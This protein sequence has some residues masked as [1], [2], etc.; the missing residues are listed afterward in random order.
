MTI[1]IYEVHAFNR[2]ARHWAMGIQLAPI[3]PSL[4]PAHIAGNL[5]A[6]LA[7]LVVIILL[8]LSINYTLHWSPSTEPTTP[9]SD[10]PLLPLTPGRAYSVT[11]PTMLDGL[12]IILDRP[13]EILP[14]GSLRYQDCNVSIPLH[15]VL[16]WDR[17]WFTVLENA[18]LEL[19]RSNITIVRDPLHE[20]IL[21]CS[22]DLESFIE[23]P[24]GV[25]ILWRVVNLAGCARP[26]LAFDTSVRGGGCEIRVFAQPSPGAEARFF[27]SFVVLP[28][29]RSDWTHHEVDLTSL[30]GMMPRLMI[31]IVAAD[32][33]TV[34]LRDPRI[35][36]DG[37]DP[38]LDDFGAE[39]P[40]KNGWGS[41][42]TSATPEFFSFRDR[43]T[44]QSS[45]LQVDGRLI[46]DSSRVIAPQNMTRWSHWYPEDVL[47]WED[48]ER[49]LYDSTDWGLGLEVRGGSL[50]MSGSVL[51][52]VPLLCDAAIVSITDSTLVGHD[53]LATLH[54]CQGDVTGSDLVGG[55][56]VDG[57]VELWSQAFNYGTDWAL[58]VEGTAEGGMLA[59][60]RTTFRNVPVGLY[61]RN[62]NVTVDACE[63]RAVGCL[64]LW[65]HGTDLPGGWED[66]SRTNLF[67]DCPSFLYLETHTCEV[68][69]LGTGANGSERVIPD[70]GYLDYRM[71]E[72]LP[73]VEL[74]HYMS[75]RPRSLRVDMPTV[76]VGPDGVPDT[77][78]YLL[79]MVSVPSVSDVS[80]GH[81]MLLNISSEE[82]HA[83]RHVSD[84]PDSDGEPPP[85]YSS[86][87]D[88]YPPFAL[89]WNPPLADGIIALEVTLFDGLLKSELGPAELE[90]RISVNETPR[91]AFRVRG[92]EL[93]DD[94]Y[95]DHPW[96]QANISLP[97]GASSV[98]LV[99]LADSGD[100][101]G[102]KAVFN[103]TVPFLRVGNDTPV[104]DVVEGIGSGAIILVDNRVDLTI[105]EVAPATVEFE[106]G[107]YKVLDLHLF[108]CE[109]T[110]VTI[111][112]AFAPNVTYMFIEE[113]GAGTLTVQQVEC[114][115]IWLSAKEG[116]AIIQNV[117]C[118]ALCLFAVTATIDVSASYEGSHLYMDLCQCSTVRAT[119]FELDI[120]ND[121]GWPGSSISLDDCMIVGDEPRTY[122]LT[123][124]GVVA[125]RFTDC[126]FRN[127]TLAKHLERTRVGVD[128]E[129]VRCEFQ[130]P[131]AYLILMDHDD[132][133]WSENVVVQDC[134]FV[135]VGTGVLAPTQ[136]MNTLFAS[137]ELHDGARA[138]ALASWNVRLIFNG[139]P[140]VALPYDV[141]FFA[142]FTVQDVFWV[143]ISDWIW[144]AGHISVDVSMD[145]PMA[146]LP[147]ESLIKIESGGVTVWFAT[148]T[149]GGGPVDV[150]IPEWEHVAQVVDA[151]LEGEGDDEFW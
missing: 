36:E 39:V 82:R 25:P 35:V 84:L 14:G 23:A 34:F 128:L 40:F 70:Y 27:R 10:E 31:T 28:S 33:E 15:D 48:G 93:S 45:L 90:L 24:R 150:Q 115:E 71:E 110:N 107:S 22:G 11:T 60:A 105:D 76:A 133:P 17:P 30:A 132:G 85:T 114:Q 145:V 13:I 54:G 1:H 120:R 75:E 149:I 143:D 137:S 125:L 62:A 146:H 59:I 65:A 89:K 55:S 58:C 95:P 104:K 74:V 8:L 6:M 121:I 21:C 127:I 103:L 47:H 131:D 26:V 51:A 63:F 57:A 3:S 109:G 77:M 136:F 97:S 56:F 96:V 79:L 18:S 12:D 134:A 44:G 91:S 73:Q 88:E 64:A 113:S 98:E 141:T 53:T 68:E 86:D 116:S 139:V 42:S 50:R 83:L 41:A 7:V 100:G 69:L 147:M 111:S 142:S 9:S 135:G 94:F 67:A 144:L 119:G 72:R 43:A 148:I 117:T 99:L 16:L 4:R 81:S 37:K 61:A 2:V 5:R 129:L 29:E 124:S 138:L 32:A 52:E 66:T 19:V 122:D 112:R 46:L 49:S 108:L 102:L 20:R 78:E 151:L 118:D 126:T 80:I 38:P 87:W 130:A 106:G 123:E 101:T 140:I 92:E